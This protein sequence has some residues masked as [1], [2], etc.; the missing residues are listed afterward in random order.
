MAEDVF[1]EEFIDEISLV[2]PSTNVNDENFNLPISELQHNLRFLLNFISVSS[3]SS[4]NYL[5]LLYG[6]LL[7]YDS[8]GQKIFFNGGNFD[9]FEKKNSWIAVDDGE[10]TNDI[11]IQNEGVE[12]LLVYSGGVSF[13]DVNGEHGRYLQREFY[14]PPQ[15]RGTE[16]VFAIKGTGVYT[17]ENHQAIEFDYEIPY[18]DS[19]MVP[20]IS[21]VGEPDCITSGTTGTTG[22]TGTPTTGC[23]TTGTTG[24]PDIPGITCTPDLT[25]GCYSRYEDLGIE[26]IGALDTVEE[27]VVLGPWPHHNL[28]AEQDLW[29]P[30]Y[31]TSA[32]AFR[33]GQNTSSIKIRIRRTREDGAIAISQMFLGGLPNP[34]SQ[35]EINNLDINELYNYNQGITKWNVTTVNGRHVAEDCEGAKLPN[36]MTKEQWLCLSQFNRKIDEFD[37]DAE[38]GPRPNELEFLD[39]PSGVS[40]KTHGLEFDP[41]YTRFAHFDM[42]VDGPDPGLCYLGISYFVNENEFTPDDLNCCPNGTCGNMKFDVWVAV[43][44]TGD[45]GNPN[46]SEYKKFSY[47]VPIPEYVKDGKMGYFEIYGNFYEDLKATRGSIAYFVISRDGESDTD[48]LNGNFIL[49]GCKTGLAIPTDDKPESGTYPDLFV[50]EN[51]EC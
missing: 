12:R 43:V 20:G 5:S 28:Y 16:L 36:I 33:V 7:D 10:V 37:W 40:P 32:V 50:G 39:S 44:N 9:C 2:N 13:T 15:L 42:R 51:S 49:V 25:T 41:E 27:I 31:R 29:L 14:I 38:N 21:S 17:E 4:P 22:T 26:V 3:A 11:D 48:T 19:S 24:T 47:T 45:F 35:Y 23:P 34:W 1:D 30:E 18:C 6:N 8:S 46:D